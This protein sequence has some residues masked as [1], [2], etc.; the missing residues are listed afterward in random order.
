M[1]A[2]N[3]L[4]ALIRTVYDTLN[5]QKPKIDALNQG[6]RGLTRTITGMEKTDK[7]MQDRYVLLTAD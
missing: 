4:E 2:T 3:R 1:S 7:Y 5:A 6:N